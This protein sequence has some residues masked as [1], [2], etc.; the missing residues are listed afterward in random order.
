MPFELSFSPPLHR[1]RT[2]D[3]FISELTVGLGRLGDVGR[4]DADVVLWELVAA[5]DLWP[6]ES[7]GLHDGC[8]ALSDRLAEPATRVYGP[9]HADGGKERAQKDPGARVACLVHQG[10]P[11]ARLLPHLGHS[12]VLQQVGQKHLVVADAV[13][14]TQVVRD[15]HALGGLVVDAP[16]AEG[17]AL[18][19][20]VLILGCL[21]RA[22][23]L[24]QHHQCQMRQHLLHG[25]KQKM[26]KETMDDPLYKAQWQNDL[27]A[28]YF[29]CPGRNWHCQLHSSSSVCC[30]ELTHKAYCQ[31]HTHT[32][33]K[34]T[35][36]V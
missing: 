12:L 23:Q 9:V 3:L 25:G 5:E 8:A 31:I 6:W 7:E 26:Q 36:Q 20:D 27:Q 18:P 29:L 24:G 1:N 19:G 33:L 22:C 14:Q 28:V 30:L 16:A 4:A 32:Q 2:H 17:L 10:H 13:A 21:T 34:K 15:G 35:L 11:A